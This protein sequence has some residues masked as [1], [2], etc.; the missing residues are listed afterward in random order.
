MKT[1]IARVCQIGTTNYVDYK[2]E[3]LTVKQYKKKYG[4]DIEI[5]KNVKVCEPNQEKFEKFPELQKYIEKLQKKVTEVEH[6]SRAMKDFEPMC[7]YCHF[8]DKCFVHDI[9]I[10]NNLRRVEETQRYS[11]TELAVVTFIALVVLASLIIHSLQH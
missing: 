7:P 2:G 9:D 1:N 11:N 3:R 5:P 6:G 8:D 10:P 4:V